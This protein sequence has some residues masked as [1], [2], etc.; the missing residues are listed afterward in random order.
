MWRTEFAGFN[1]AVVKATAN[2]TANSNTTNHR[3]HRRRGR[4]L[5]HCQHD[6]RLHYRQKRYHHRTPTNG[7]DCF[8]T[9]STSFVASDTATT[10]TTT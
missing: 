2:T 9:A 7:H 4:R 3:T 6:H 8:A 1:A 5:R 10:T